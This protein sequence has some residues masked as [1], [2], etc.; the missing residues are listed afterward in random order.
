MEAV[1]VRELLEQAVLR[2]READRYLLEKNLNERC[3]AGRLAMYLQELFPRLHVDVEYNR[4]GNTPK[5]L[6]LPEEC[7]NFWNE[8]GEALV[9]PD[10]IVHRRGEAGPNILV[11]ELKKTTNRETPDCD[12]RRVEAF[13]RQLGYELGALITCE[14]RAGRGPDVEVSAWFAD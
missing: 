13:R 2:V 9:V 12:R 5:R 4:D 11:V 1:E 3:I 14:T 7:A 10:V 8:D 6:D